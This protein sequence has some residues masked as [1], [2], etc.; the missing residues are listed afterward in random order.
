MDAFRIDR[1]PM[2]S[3]SIR[4]GDS[5]SSFRISK[6][7]RNGDATSLVG[8]SEPPHQQHSR[9]I[10]VMRKSS[11]KMQHSHEHGKRICIVTW[12][13]GG[14][15]GTNLQAYALQHFIESLGYPVHILSSIPDFGNLIDVVYH[16][17]NHLSIYRIWLQMRHVFDKSFQLVPD[18]PGIRRWTR[19]NL[20]ISKVLSPHQLRKLVFE[21]DCFISG[22]DQLWNTF[23]R[24]DPTMYLEFA[25]GKK[26]ISYATSLGT[27]GVNPDYVN[28]L[29]TWL[30]KY[31]HISV[32]EQSSVRVLE[33]ITGRTDIAHVLDPTFLLSSKEWL[34]FCVSSIPRFNESTSFILCYLL[35]NSN[36]YENQVEEVRSKTG[37]ARIV[38]VPSAENPSFSIKG[39][40]VLKNLS[41]PEFVHLLATA[42]VVCTDSFH[43]SALCINLSKPFVEFMRFENDNP[44][45]QNCRILDVLDHFRL[46]GRIFNK[47]SNS[48]F[49]ELDFSQSQDILKRDRLFSERYLRNAIED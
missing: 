6:R 31:R 34:S 5:G 21:T 20:H 9:T 46:I 4:P 17:V 39:S 25:K 28:T 27:R 49:Q 15:F 36:N 44:D 48:W 13:G 42:T 3:G 19:R 1:I 43:A 7:Q 8:P 40:T 32:R 2:C 14:N 29:R 24:V 38:L 23:F 33:S 10:A 22:S 12:Q 11:R 47:D 41:P 45:S 26:C 35:G 16:S 37:I 18:N 30:Q